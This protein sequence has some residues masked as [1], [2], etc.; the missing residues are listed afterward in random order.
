VTIGMATLLEARQIVLMVTGSAKAGILRR[1]LCGPM[2]A[3]VPASW[4]R[5]A[6]D[7]LTVLADDQAA[8]SCHALPWQQETRWSA[9]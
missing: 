8:A 6:G 1:A 3:E 4:L 5:L 7:R 2:T 9:L